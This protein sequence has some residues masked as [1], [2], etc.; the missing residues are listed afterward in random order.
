MPE[1]TE[2]EIL[3]QL[4]PATAV[5]E[6]NARDEGQTPVRERQERLTGLA[7]GAALPSAFHACNLPPETAEQLRAR[8]GHLDYWI[9]AYESKV[10]SLLEARRLAAEQLEGFSDKA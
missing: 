8:I 9:S 3:C 10:E 7:E 1:K 2:R 6:S 4:P 5:Q